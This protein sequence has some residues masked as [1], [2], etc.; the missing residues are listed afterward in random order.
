MCCTE[1]NIVQSIGC[2]CILSLISRRNVS[3]NDMYV[4]IVIVFSYSLTITV[5]FIVVLLVFCR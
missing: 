4:L 3:V 5:Y 2:G 1:S